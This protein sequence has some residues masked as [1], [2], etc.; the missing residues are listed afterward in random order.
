MSGRNLVLSLIGAGCVTAA[1]AGSFYAVR[2]N[3]DE[4][5]VQEATPVAA[6]DVAT[7]EAPRAPDPLPA[8]APV[9]AATPWPA[10]ASNLA[11]APSRRRPVSEPRVADRKPADVERPANPAPAS[12]TAPATASAS[13]PPKSVDPVA[14][15]PGTA[16][17]PIESTT[18]PATPRTQYDEIT[19]KDDSVIGIQLETTL[20]SDT[21]KIEDK[22]VARVSRDLTL[23]GRTASPSGA[24]LEGN[25]TAVDRGG[26]FKERA[27]LGIRFTTLVLGESMRVPIQTETIFRVGDSPA[28]QA[29]AKIGASA[30]VGSILGAVIGGKKG[31]AI[32]SAAGAAGGTAAVAASGP[33]DVRL[34]PGTP[35]TVRLVAPVTFLIERLQ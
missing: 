6:T 28:P 10:P 7:V 16:A 9:P 8:A 13:A 12:S 27:R 29:T 5:P 2:V 21:A 30:V 33:R 22:V 20:S 17:P 4:R 18:A 35:L 11:A 26:K 23:G 34:Q 24:R 15:D 31:A 14:A 19:I 25:V 32:G 1:G 3:S